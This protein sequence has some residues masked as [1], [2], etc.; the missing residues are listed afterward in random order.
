MRGSTFVLLFFFG[1]LCVYVSRHLALIW[2]S[3]FSS[4]SFHSVL[5]VCRTKRTHCLRVFFFFASLACL[6]C[7][8][9]CFM[10]K[11]HTNCQNYRKPAHRFHY[12]RI[13][14]VCAIFF[15][16][17]YVCFRIVR[18]PIKSFFFSFSLIFIVDNI[19]FWQED[20]HINQYNT[21]QCMPAYCLFFL[22][23]FNKISNQFKVW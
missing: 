20:K 23:S 17:F 4:S 18:L 13:E 9:C 14:I 11:W 7:S 15:G 2:F 5:C 1:Q 6:P 21:I 22:E 12:V 19:C 8:L 16:H 10:C 3:L